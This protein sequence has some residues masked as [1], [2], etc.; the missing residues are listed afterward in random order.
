MF[1]VLCSLFPVPC[2]LFP[3]PLAIDRHESS[4]YRFIPDFVLQKVVYKLRNL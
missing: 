1:S 3:V 4:W 2:S